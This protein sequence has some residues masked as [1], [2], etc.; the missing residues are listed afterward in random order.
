[1]RTLYL[2]FVI[3]WM[4]KAKGRGGKD[5]RQAAESVGWW[6][7]DG[8]RAEENQ[9]TGRRVWSWQR[10]HKTV[11]NR[12]SMTVAD[13]QADEITRGSEHNRWKVK[14]GTLELSNPQRMKT[15]V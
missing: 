3:V 5:G 4:W 2:V 11:G 10:K 13:L 7:V 8:Q 14:A 15:M 1:M 6:V 9:K 12:W